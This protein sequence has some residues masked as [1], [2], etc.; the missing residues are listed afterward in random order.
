MK[1]PLIGS[2]ASGS[3]RP[4][5]LGRRRALVLGTGERAR[6]VAQLVERPGQGGHRVI[7]F[8]DD[9]PQPGDVEALGPRFL[10]GLSRFSATCASESIDSVFFAL[11]R[12]FLAHDSI[13]N[14]VAACEILG[15]DLVIPLDLFDTRA[16][17]SVMR[18]LDG[19]P[20]ISYTQPI[21]RAGWALA[22]KRA[23]D[24]AGAV[25]MLLIGLPLWLVI[26]LLVKL[27]S[28]GPVLFVQERCGLHGRR[29]KLYKFRTMYSDA[30]Q[31]RD[32][33]VDLN[34]VS[35]PVFKI[36]SDPRV[37]RVGRLLRKTSI[38]EFPQFVNVLLGHMSLVGPRPPVPR[39]VEDYE[40]DHLGR[41]SMRPGITG[42]WQV[43]GRS[44]IP[45]EDWVK[46]DL[47]YARRWSL[48]LDFEVLLATIPAVLSARGAS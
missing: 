22:T 9:N 38:D 33:L 48:R 41:L 26:A 47:E 17:P 28:R 37:T 18:N 19:V 43:S 36:R 30:E 1:L 34:E 12:R 42:L 21:R 5:P 11:P 39:E 10:G 46:L 27:D 35:G 32:A 4:A 14:V 44:D 31:R 6:R 25:A 3:A 2:G 20:C 45:F 15:I 24:V 40:M 13:A 23:M 16:A 8:V 7:G 29:F